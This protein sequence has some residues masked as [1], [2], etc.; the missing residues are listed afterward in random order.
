MN[1]LS[2]A[3]RAYIAG[4]LDGDGSIYVQL[5]PN[6]TYRFRFQIAPLIVFFQSKKER[7]GLERIW[8]ITGVGYLRDRNDGITEY[9][10]GDTK[11]I[12]ALLDNV[13]PFL[14]LKKR[15][16]EIMMQILHG[17][18]LVKSGT[19]FLKLCAL[20]DRFRVLNYSKRRIQV[21]QVVK[22]ALLAE[23]LLTP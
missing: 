5:K 2:V 9:I 1:R 8:H 11:S 17:K 4:F 13:T 21:S 3:Q 23:G 10:I 7:A 20:V 19:D 15:Q 6:K 18:S 16:A 12:I 14:Y 22:K